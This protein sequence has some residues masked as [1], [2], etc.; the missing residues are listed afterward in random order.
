VTNKKREYSNST[1]SQNFTPIIYIQEKRI[2]L[3]FFLNGTHYKSCHK[4]LKKN[5]HKWN[6]KVNNNIQVRSKNGKGPEK[7][8]HS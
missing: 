1:K 5:I 7:R 3:I 8:T 4:G 2:L 6:V